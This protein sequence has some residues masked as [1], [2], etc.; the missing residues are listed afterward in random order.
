M[1]TGP[2]Y[3]ACSLGQ[4]EMAT[5]LV[6]VGADVELP[7]TNGRGHTA[8]IAACQEGHDQIIRMLLERGGAEANVALHTKAPPR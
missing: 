5:M 1:P 6:E 3:G 8:L 2:L 7:T 4:L